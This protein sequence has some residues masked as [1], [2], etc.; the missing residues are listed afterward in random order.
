[1]NPENR[2]YV[3]GHRG[4]AGSAILRA[5]QVKGFQSLIT[6]TREELDLTDAQATK[7][8]FEKECPEYVVVAATKVGGIHANNTFPAE[9]L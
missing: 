5:L 2:I 3:A 1:M 9:F 4:L 6:R 7:K 8:F